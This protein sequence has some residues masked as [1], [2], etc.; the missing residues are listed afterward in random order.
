MFAIAGQYRLQ[1]CYMLHNDMTR[2]EFLSL[3]GAFFGLALLSRLP[4]GS[5]T[6]PLVRRTP[7][8]YSNSTYGGSTTK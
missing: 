6:N 1:S 4:F 8:S 5:R 2:K 7:N 3:A